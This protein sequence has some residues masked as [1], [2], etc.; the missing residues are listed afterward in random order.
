[1]SVVVLCII[2]QHYIIFAVLNSAIVIISFLNIG[3]QIIP[4]SIAAD[5]SV[6]LFYICNF[7]V[8]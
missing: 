5:I 7:I 3:N 6:T 1:M 2:N 4:V 8:W